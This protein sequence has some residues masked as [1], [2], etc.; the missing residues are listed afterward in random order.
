MTR[1]KTCS[2][3]ADY[4]Q[5]VELTGDYAQWL[6]LDLCFQNFDQE[7]QTFPAMYGAGTGIFLLAFAE[8]DLAGGVGLRRLDEQICEMKRLYVYDKFKGSGAGRLLCQEL[9]DK[10][11]ELGYRRMRLDTL[12]RMVAANRLYEKLGFRDI[13][14]YRYNPDPTTRYMELNLYALSA[15]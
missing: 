12:P 8:N 9:I 4:Q 15:G 11:R 3:P 5:A 10:A 7:L 14:A 1:I 6:D 2:T 13:P